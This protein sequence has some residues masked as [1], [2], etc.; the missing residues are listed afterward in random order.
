[1]T[2]NLQVFPFLKI[3]VFFIREYLSVKQAMI[4]LACREGV[5]K[6]MEE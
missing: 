4:F 3:F 6:E 5:Q 2:F 1:M